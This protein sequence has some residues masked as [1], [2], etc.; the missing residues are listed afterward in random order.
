MRPGP[1]CVRSG[2]GCGSSTRGSAISHAAKLAAIS[3]YAELFQ[4]QDE[5][6]SLAERRITV[7]MCQPR[8][9]TRGGGYLTGSGS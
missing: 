2:S 5:M 8:V 1:A 7:D 3:P 9:C 6:L 4:D